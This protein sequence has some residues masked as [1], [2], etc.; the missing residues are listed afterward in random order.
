MFGGFLLAQ[1]KLRT[2]Q[3]HS[4]DSAQKANGIH[5]TKPRGSSVAKFFIWFCSKSESLSPKR[6]GF[7]FHTSDL[8]GWF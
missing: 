2:T 3:L 1:Q 6:P 4:E 5:A 8:L 7:P